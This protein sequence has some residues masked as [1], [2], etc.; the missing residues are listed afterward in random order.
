MEMGNFQLFR[1]K[2][3]YYLNLIVDTKKSYFKYFHKSSCLHRAS[4]VSKTLFIVTTDAHCYKNHRMLKQFKIITLDPTCFGSRRNHNQEAVL[5][6]DKTTRVGYKVV[7]R[8][9]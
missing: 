4:I 3:T 8:L 7:A 5:C 9:L 2:I 6:L 1:G